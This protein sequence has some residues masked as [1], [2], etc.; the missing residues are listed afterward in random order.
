M[1]IKDLQSIVMSTML[2]FAVIGSYQMN[3]R[4]NR[5]RKQS[6]LE[7]AVLWI[8]LGFIMFIVALTMT[9][10]LFGEDNFLIWLK[11]IQ[12]ATAR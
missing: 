4:I 8:G 5:G 1:S 3:K 7:I 6:C 11:H 12:Q 2:T 10:V 9:N